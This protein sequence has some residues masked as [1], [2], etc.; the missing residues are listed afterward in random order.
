MF[1]N[2]QYVTKDYSCQIVDGLAIFKWWLRYD[3]NDL[4]YYKNLKKDNK[5][6]DL[7]SQNCRLVFYLNGLEVHYY[8]RFETYKDI[9]DRLK[10]ERYGDAGTSTLS[11]DNVNSSE[12]QRLVFISISA[13]G[14]RSKK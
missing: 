1:K 8:N 6:A 14:I 5:D 12:E 2:V 3:T 11:N 4:K 7:Q 13:V 10:C 9:E